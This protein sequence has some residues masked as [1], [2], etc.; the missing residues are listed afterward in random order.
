M[1]RA[2][3]V[4]QIAPQWAADLDARENAQIAHARVYAR[5]WAHVGAPSHGQFILIAKLAAK[6]DALEAREGPSMER[7]D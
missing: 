4:P 5:S 7:P 3:T 2:H 1:E 6:L